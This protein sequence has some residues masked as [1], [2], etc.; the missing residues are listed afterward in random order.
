MLFSFDTSRL[1][2]LICF[3]CTAAV[4]AGV[5]GYMQRSMQGIAAALAVYMRTEVERNGMAAR[6][7][8]FMRIDE[9]AVGIQ[10]TCR[11]V[12]HAATAEFILG[13]GFSAQNIKRKSVRRR[14]VRE[15]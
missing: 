14:P 3:A 4:A 9:P 13:S 15:R 5:F 6:N 12:H 1:E 2:Q 7:L 10:I 8:Y 11:A